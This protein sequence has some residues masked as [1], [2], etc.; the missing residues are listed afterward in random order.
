[1]LFACADY[2]KKNSRYVCIPAFIKRNTSKRS[3]YDSL[4]NP[5]SKKAGIHIQINW[6]RTGRLCSRHPLCSKTR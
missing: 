6:N 1:M 4:Y 3:E 2:L 5:N